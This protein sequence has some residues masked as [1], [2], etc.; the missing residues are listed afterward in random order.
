MRCARCGALPIEEHSL[1]RSE[2]GFP[3][4]PGD[5]GL[6]EDLPEEGDVDVTSMRIGNTGS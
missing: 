5:I 3:V 6:P 1:R 2:C 4:G